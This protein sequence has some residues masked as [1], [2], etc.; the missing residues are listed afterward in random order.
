MQIINTVVNF[1]TNV[2]ASALLPFIIMLLGLYF[3]MGIKKALRNGLMVGIGFLGI[4]TILSLLTGAMSSISEYYSSLGSGFSVVDIGWAG[5][6]AAAWSTPFAIL[7]IP[8]GF[9]LNFFL[10]KARFTKTLNVDLWNYWHF[11]ITSC[12]VYYVLKIAGVSTI[13]AGA[14]G[15]VI[16]LICLIIV[17]KIADKTAKSWQDYFGQEGTAVTTQFAMATAYPIALLVNL[18]ID[19]IPGLNKINLDLDDVS[20]KL[21]I[22]GDSAVMSFFIGVLLCILTKQSAANTLTISIT[23]AGAIVMLPRMVSLL[24][25]GLGPIGS[26]ASAFMQKKLGKDYE[27]YIGMD[28]ALGLGDT[29]AIQTALIMIPITILLGFI[30]P[31]VNYFP[32]GLVGGMVYTTTVSSWASNGNVFKTIM[33]AI[34]ITVYELV[35]MSFMAGLT[36]A[37]VAASGTMDLSSGMQV[38]GTVCDTGYNVIIAIFANIFN[39]I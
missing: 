28:V 9:I 4:S 34:G 31:G 18:I 14:I 6:G 19:K 22:L 24:M 10:V 26:Y 8:I 16:A 25:E 39:L 15:I 2:G 30:V 23:I 1:I 5:I 17:L 37:V 3:R 21:G 13:V 11:L 7:V 36:T 29:C 38:V 27:V 20:S 35:A 32:I 33:S 12:M